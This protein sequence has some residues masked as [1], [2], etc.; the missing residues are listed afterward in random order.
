MKDF[1]TT[2]EARLAE[3]RITDES[4]HAEIDKLTAALNVAYDL[5]E[6]VTKITPKVRP[7]KSSRKVGIVPNGV[8]KST[9]SI[10]VCV[11]ELLKANGGRMHMKDI[12]AELSSQ[13]IL[14]ISKNTYPTVYNSV[15]RSPYFQFFGN[16]EFGLATIQ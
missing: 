15:K 14:K 7:T 6:P 5:C 2:A 9:K 1:I 8:N 13:G 16:G 11:A 12:V 3:L 10:A 4:V